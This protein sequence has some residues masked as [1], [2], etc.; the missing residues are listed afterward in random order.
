M[1][2]EDEDKFLDDDGFFDEK[3]DYA[4]PKEIAETLGLPVNLLVNNSDSYVEMCV[5]NAYLYARSKMLQKEYD[6]TRW[7]R[8]EKAYQAALEWLSDRGIGGAE[9]YVPDLNLVDMLAEHLDLH[10]GGLRFLTATK[11]EAAKR[12]AGELTAE[13]RKA[14]DGALQWLQQDARIREKNAL[15]N[16]DVLRRKKEIIQAFREAAATAHPDK[17]GTSEAFRQAIDD[18]DAALLDLSTMV[19]GVAKEA[20]AKQDTVRS[21]A[22]AA[23][24][25]ARRSES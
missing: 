22:W 25:K 16:E 17:G 19:S 4:L 24:R 12:S 15:G 8:T 2:R 10:I 9:K 3:A 14:Y 18:R 7:R 21:A 1:R 13:G 6:E 20:K 11:L 5:R 23:Y